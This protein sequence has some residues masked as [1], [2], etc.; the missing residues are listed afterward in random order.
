MSDAP[1][2]PQTRP[3]PQKSRTRVVLEALLW[4]AAIVLAW[5]WGQG[6]VAPDIKEGK[7]APDFAL[8]S[9]SGRQFRLSDHRDKVIVINFWATWCG[10][11]RMELPALNGL[12]REYP[13]EKFLL[14]A[15]ALQS[16]PEDVK[17]MAQELKLEMPVLFGNGT[18]DEQYGIRGFPTTVIVGP[19][20]TVLDVFGGYTTE[21]SL[22]RAVEAALKLKTEGA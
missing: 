9:T 15:V 19:G 11:C 12:Y 16:D 14:L 4:T 18:V 8:V 1:S 17:A 6:R 20:G 3:P 13:P 22:K 21:W 7:P 10:P 5:V 2:E